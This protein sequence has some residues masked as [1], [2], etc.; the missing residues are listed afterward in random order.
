MA[1]GS[2][3]DDHLEIESSSSSWN[4]T[5]KDNIPAPVLDTLDHA[6]PDHGGDRVAR[7]DT[8][9]TDMIHSQSGAMDSEEG[10]QSASGQ[11]RPDGWDKEKRDRH[12]LA[13]RDKA[14]LSLGEKLEIIQRNIKSQ[15]GHPE[16]RTQA[17]LASMFGKSR[18]AIY[19]IV[20]PD[21]VRQLQQKAAAGLDHGLKRHTWRRTA[22]WNGVSWT[23]FVTRRAQV[24]SN[25]VLRRYASMHQKSLRNLG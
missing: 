7:S 5:Q 18:A 17:Q 24:A 20:R 10:H 19:K 6:K 2:P 3:D 1:A 11:A 8:T 15:P 16:F 12:S 22:S 9:S 23:L 14:R 4:A 13:C 21:N 25:A